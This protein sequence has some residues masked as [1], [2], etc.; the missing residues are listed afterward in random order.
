MDLRLLNRHGK[1][2]AETPGPEVKPDTVSP[3]EQASRAQEKLVNRTLQL[4]ADYRK[5]IPDCFELSQC[6][7]KL[8]EAIQWAQ[9]ALTVRGARPDEPEKKPDAPPEAKG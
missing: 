9:T 7:I 2:F 5:H 8:N 3:M 6:I 4:M 1:K